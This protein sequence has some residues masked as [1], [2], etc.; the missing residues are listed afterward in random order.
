[1]SEIFYSFVVQVIVF[2]GGKS[3]MS[4]FV[5][6]LSRRSDAAIVRNRRLH[7]ILTIR[8]F[9]KVRTDFY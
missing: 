1:M 2:V 3:T 7:A 5:A 6:W 8:S 4:A 9:I